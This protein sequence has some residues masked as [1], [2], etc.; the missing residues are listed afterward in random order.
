MGPFSDIKETSQAVDELTK[1]EQSADLP[2][3][4]LNDQKTQDWAYTIVGVSGHFIGSAMVVFVVAYFLLSLSDDLLKQMVASMPSFFEKRNVVELVQNVERGMP[5]RVQ[6]KSRAC[7]VNS[8]H[9]TGVER[10][11]LAKLICP[12]ET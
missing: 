9:R 2:E 11:S 3:I 8:T 1:D 10:L 6:P 12:A 5:Y 4:K 7:W